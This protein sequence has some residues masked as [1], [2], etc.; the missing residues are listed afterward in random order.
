MRTD[1]FS[2][3]TRRAAADCP[4][5]RARF[6]AYYAWD[7]CLSRNTFRKLER[8]LHACA[9]CRCAYEQA[10]AAWNRVEEDLAARDRRL[11][12]ATRL[13]EGVEA[14]VEMLTRERAVVSRRT[15]LPGR[16]AWGLGAAAVALIVLPIWAHGARQFRHAGSHS[17]PVS[18]AMGAAGLV[19]GSGPQPGGGQPAQ[20]QPATR[21]APRT[22][23]GVDPHDVSAPLGRATAAALVAATLPHTAEEYEA[24]ARKTF[25]HV[26]AAYDILTAPDSGP[27]PS[28]LVPTVLAGD[29]RAE[30]L[31]L[32]ALAD[33]HNG[34]L[35]DGA[36]AHLPEWAA[37]QNAPPFSGWRAL[38]A[39]SGVLFRFDFPCALDEP[40][41]APSVRDVENALR[42][43][44]I[45]I[46]MENAPETN[47]PPANG[48]LVPP[49][50]DHTLAAD[51]ALARSVVTHLCIVEEL[52]AVDAFRPLADA[53][54]ALLIDRLDEDETPCDR[55]G[56]AADL[57]RL[58]SNH[59]ATVNAVIG[60]D[61]APQYPKS[62]P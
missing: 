33:Q 23:F 48:I 16:W 36:P 22:A 49:G 12:P 26:M 25:P 29:V 35:W 28:G 53:G 41:V 15:V 32:A 44:G 58:L 24:W 1:I 3:L 50:Y 56:L 47:P 17:A 38:L 11:A 18:P 45:D 52:T 31:P 46:A 20:P 7:P 61:V 10:H 43:A 59:F 4:W 51:M 62:A 34:P 30:L 27:V 2:W 54:R 21:Q 39:G 19:T 57:R 40:C 55:P 42:V 37:G 6:H 5:A 13:A 9:A 14:R 60:L 8:H